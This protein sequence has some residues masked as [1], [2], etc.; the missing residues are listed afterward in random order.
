MPPA[1]KHPCG[2]PGCPELVATGAY[3]EKHRGQYDQERGS[4]ASRGYDR[5]WREF[6]ILYLQDHPLC[7]DCLIENVVRAAEEIHHTIKVRKRPDL[8]YEESNLLALCKPHH[9]VR[10]A[11]GE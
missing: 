8:Q 4:A 7:V 2:Y 10:T 9:S 1:A 11:R 5:K 6:R 3:C